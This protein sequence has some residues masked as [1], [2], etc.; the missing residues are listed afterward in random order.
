MI[1]LR[2]TRTIGPLVRPAQDIVSALDDAAAS[3]R[4]VATGTVILARCRSAPFPELR[5]TRTVRLLRAIFSPP[6]PPETADDR[7]EER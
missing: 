1:D 3:S 2:D 4:F 6:D 5:E 7:Q